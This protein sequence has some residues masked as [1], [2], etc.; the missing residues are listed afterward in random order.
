MSFLKSNENLIVE[1]KEHK[2][3]EFYFDGIRRDIQFEQFFLFS[4]PTS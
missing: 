2:L 1:I 4:V 3:E